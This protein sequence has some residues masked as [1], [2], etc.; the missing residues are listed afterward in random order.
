MS[1]QI[2]EDDCSKVRRKV[3]KEFV[4]FY[5]S[6]VAIIIVCIAAFGW[7]KVSEKMLVISIVLLISLIVFASIMIYLRKYYLEVYEDKIELSTLFHKYTICLK[8][9]T[10]FYYKK[11]ETSEVTF[12]TII[13]KD[14]E[15]KLFTEYGKELIDLLN[16]SISDE[17]KLN[18]LSK[19][20]NKNVDKFIKVL[21]ILTCLS[22][23]VS[24]LLVIILGEIFVF[25]I[26]G[27]LR[28]SWIFLLFI[29]IP[30]LSFIFCAKSKTNQYKDKKS[31]AILSFVLIVVLGFSGIVNNNVSYNNEIINEINNKTSLEIPNNLKIVNYDKKDYIIGYAKITDKETKNS[32]QNYVYLSN[33]WLTNIDD[34]KND[35]TYT[36]TSNLNSAF[37]K[38]SFKYFILYNITTDTFNSI[39]TENDKQQNIIFIA[40]NT[41]V[42]R[43]MYFYNYCIN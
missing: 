20:Q 27:I 39:D 18:S 41:S 25:S 22:V 43:I 11:S 14:K 23:P 4:G 24:F 36:I 8:D 1:K 16:T 34:L 5:I 2:I 42:G 37:T 31:V 10:A 15:I 30:L 3:I 29:P 40:C 35:L 17:A 7:N 21:S 32:F 38:Y 12:F 28:Y 9:I 19:E 33:L 26:Y 6:V 13:I